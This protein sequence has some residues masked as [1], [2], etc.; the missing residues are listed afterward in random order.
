MEDTSENKAR[1]FA[2][3]WGQKIVAVRIDDGK[4]R[5][6]YEVGNNWYCQLED[7]YL[8]LKPLSQIIDEDAIEVIGGVECNLRMNDEDSGFFGMSPSEIFVASLYSKSES[9]HITPRKLDYLRSKGY[10]LPWLGVLVEQ[11]I[12]WGWIKL[13]RENDKK[14]KHNPN[15][16]CV[17]FESNLDSTS[18][19]ATICKHCGKEKWTHVNKVDGNGRY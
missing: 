18:A 6:G 9:Y 8:E 19:S 14:N 11:Q 3:Y 2:Q 5:K 10:A 16:V 15:G 4:D 13:K 1:F 17:H 12:E 7:A